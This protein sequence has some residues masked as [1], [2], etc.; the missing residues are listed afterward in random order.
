MAA[1]NLEKCRKIVGAGVN[2]WNFVQQTGG[3]APVQPVI[4]LKPTSSLVTATN[5]LAKDVVLIPKIFQNINFEA[6]LGIV[7]GKSGKNIPKEKAFDHI[8]G[9]CLSLDMTGMEFITKARENCLP[10]ALGK[11]FDTATPVSAVLP[12]D[13]FNP[14]DVKVWSKINGVTKQEESTKGMIFSIPEL[15]EFISSYMSLEENDLILT[16]TPAGAGKVEENDV[17]ECGLGDVVSMKFVV[18]REN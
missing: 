16:G 4:F 1:N 13:A 10:W 9:Y 11:A 6:E 5:D 7:I 2:Y 3:K 12:K 8:S 18:K 14:N 17:I 15:V